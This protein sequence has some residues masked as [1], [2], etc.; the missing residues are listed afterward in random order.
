MPETINNEDVERLFVTPDFSN[1]NFTSDDFLTYTCTLQPVDMYGNDITDVSQTM[2][3]SYNSIVSGSRDF[4]YSPD[5]YYLIGGE[6]GLNRSIWNDIDDTSISSVTIMKDQFELSGDIPD[7]Y[8][9]G[10]AVMIKATIRFRVQSVTPQNWDLSLYEIALTSERKIS[11]VDDPIYARVNGEQ[12]DSNDTNSVYRAFQHILETY[13]G[14]D[15]NNVDYGNLSSTRDNWHVGRTLYDR[16]SSLDYLAELCKNSFVALYPDRKGRRALS[17][18]LDNTTI[19]ATHDESEIV[20]DSIRNWRNTAQRNIYNDAT[21]DYNY[22][23]GRDKLGRQFVVTRTDEDSF[24]GITDDTDGDG[25]EDWKTY[26]AGLPDNAYNDAKLIWERFS[27]AYERINAT[28]EVPKQN[29]ALPWF[30]DRAQY[31]ASSTTGTSTDASAWKFISTLSE[32]N[33]RQRSE[34]EYSIPINS[35]NILTELCD[36]IAFN[37]QIYTNGEDVNGWVEL[38]QVDTENDIIN[39]RLIL[40][41]LDGIDFGGDIIESGSWPDTITESGS[42]TDTITE[43]AQ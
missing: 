26:V 31:D 37:D 12:V 38:V 10:Q 24:P 35:T 30:I 4:L 5:K 29:A 34:V 40:E 22:D 36:P 42:E 32:W 1:D 39:L 19:S 3:W 20:R 43:G 27:E 2:S 9:S 33:T 41:P 25:V 15:S 8:K 16:K 6:N 14:I 7:L 11:L 28:N 17:A 23:P 21:I 18:W 13:D